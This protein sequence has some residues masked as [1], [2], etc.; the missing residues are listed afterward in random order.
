[1][2]DFYYNFSKKHVYAEFLFTDTDSL[3]Y[4]IKPEDA[5]EKCFKYKHLLDF[6]NDSK[7]SKFFGETNKKVLCKMKDNSTGKLMAEFVGLKSKMYYIKKIAGKESNMT[8][9]VNIATEFNGFK[10]TLFNKK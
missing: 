7:D 10:N 2:Y 6:S 4:E 8:K 3:T 9:G 5:Y 1:M